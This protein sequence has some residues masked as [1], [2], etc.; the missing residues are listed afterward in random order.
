MVAWK[1]VESS[2]SWDIQVWLEFG[3]S[4]AIFGHV[5][6]NCVVDIVHD[7]ER[8]TVSHA[9]R[10]DT[11]ELCF[12]E[13]L[14]AYSAPRR[15]FSF[16]EHAESSVVI[17]LPVEQESQLSVRKPVINLVVVHEVGRVI[18]SHLHNGSF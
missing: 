14:H 11:P 7:S 5:S 9:A 10:N 12:W 17:A 15:H 3:E 1:L 8:L 2:V 4:L 6:D 16:R 18:R 13:V